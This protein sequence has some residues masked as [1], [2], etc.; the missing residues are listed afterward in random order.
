M[1]ARTARRTFTLKSRLD[2]VPRIFKLPKYN[3][4][5][6]L[7]KRPRKQTPEQVEYLESQKD[8]RRRLAA[9]KVAL[10][11]EEK[12]RGLAKLDLTQYSK[13]EV[14]RIL[15]LH[16]AEG[17]V[18][19]TVTRFARQFFER[20]AYELN[21]FELNL[22][23]KLVFFGKA[24]LGPADF[25]QVAGVLGKF[26]GPDPLELT[27]VSDSFC[28]EFFQQKRNQKMFANL[29]WLCHDSLLSEK[30]LRSAAKPRALFERLLYRL[31][32]ALSHKVRDGERDFDFPSLAQVL[33]I[34]SQV[35]PVGYYPDKKILPISHDYPRPPE[36]L[37]DKAWVEEVREVLRL[38]LDQAS[39]LK[40][41]HLASLVEIHR[42]MD[43]LDEDFSARAVN[44]LKSSFDFLEK[45]SFD[46]VYI[47]NR[48][49]LVAEANAGKAPALDAEIKALAQ[50]HLGPYAGEVESR[51]DFLLDRVGES[52]DP[53]GEKGQGSTESLRFQRIAD[54][55]N[56]VSDCAV[57]SRLGAWDSA[58]GPLLERIFSSVLQSLEERR[59]PHVLELLDR[60]E[61]RAG[62]SSAVLERVARWTNPLHSDWSSFSDLD[63]A[64]LKSLQEKVQ[65]LLE[66]DK[67]PEF[68]GILY[69]I[70]HRMRDSSLLSN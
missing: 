11:F 46:S 34:C 25:V 68:Q 7:Q 58:L 22:V 24:K 4:P 27:Y 13:R 21:T 65:A 42:K 32:K 59:L 38:C 52:W 16:L 30:A 35:L 49:A 50:G 61:C 20:H 1:L 47:V 6:G 17:S 48:L 67:L 44:L 15:Q 28:A 40:L 5:G 70:E 3:T 2:W 9:K 54:L 57:F 64:S 26:V 56:F 12:R 69:S 53:A 29:L 62:V 10:R 55:N 41:K 37:S 14:L 23:C 66:K 43:A 31:L 39:P 18:D 19:A 60:T 36:V 45:N 33:A 63:S 8:V 51:L